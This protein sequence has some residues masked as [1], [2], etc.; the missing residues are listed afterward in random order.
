MN[1]TYN[2]TYKQM[3]QDP[4]WKGMPC[5]HASDF[6]A[7]FQRLSDEVLTGGSLEG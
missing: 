4:G 5:I 7:V 1:C 6:V 3:M 2:S